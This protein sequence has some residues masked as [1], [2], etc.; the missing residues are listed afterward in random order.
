M[1]KCLLSITKKKKNSKLHALGIT[2]RRKLTLTLW[3]IFLSD[4]ERFNKVIIWEKGIY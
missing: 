3:S 4:T 1:P 2:K